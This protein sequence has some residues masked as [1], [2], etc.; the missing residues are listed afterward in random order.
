MSST[1]HYLDIENRRAADAL[2]H[3]SCSVVPSLRGVQRNSPHG[4]GYPWAPDVALQVTFT[5]EDK[6]SYTTPHV[7]PQPTG[8]VQLQVHARTWGRISDEEMQEINAL[9]NDG[10]T[11]AEYGDQGYGRRGT[12]VNAIRMPGEVLTQHEAETMFAPL[13]PHVVNYFDLADTPHLADLQKPGSFTS[14][15]I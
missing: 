10:N 1:E 15:R 14:L 7:D 12:H 9:G 8:N 6:Y 13:A 11:W 2:G 4:R 5:F 3:I